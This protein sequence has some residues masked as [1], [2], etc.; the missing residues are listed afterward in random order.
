M[1]WAGS[2]CT[3]VEAKDAAQRPLMQGTPSITRNYPGQNVRRAG[4]ETPSCDWHVRARQLGVGGRGTQGDR[5]ETFQV[6]WEAKGDS[7][8]E[9][10]GSSWCLSMFWRRA[11]RICSQFRY[12]IKKI[13]KVTPKVFGLNIWKLVS[14]IT[15]TRLDGKD[16]VWREAGEEGESC[17][18]S[19][20]GPELW[21]PSKH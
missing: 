5:R 20:I 19:A 6:H 13:M 9:G 11:G 12:R 17:L 21:C 2:M 10:G 1:N 15:W 18:S 14:T 8:S 3:W 16:W 7:N 4:V